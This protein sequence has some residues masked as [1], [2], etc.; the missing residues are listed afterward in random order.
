MVNLRIWSITSH[1]FYATLG[2]IQEALLSEIRGT[3][4]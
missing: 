2:I 1:L 3:P 4:Y